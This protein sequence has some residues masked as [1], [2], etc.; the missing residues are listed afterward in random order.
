MRPICSNHDLKARRGFTLLEVILAVMVLAL[1]SL[2]IFKFVQSN[3][4]A[5]QMSVEDAEEVLSVERLVALVQE[6]LYNIQPRG[7]SSFVLGQDLRTSNKDFDSMEWRSRGGPGLMTT[8]MSGEY[9]VT[10]MMKDNI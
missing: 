8:A 4:Q 6:E 9:Q 10:L 3:L 7:N 5:I 2:G 1:T